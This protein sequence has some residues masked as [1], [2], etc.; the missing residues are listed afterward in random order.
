[1]IAIVTPIKDEINNLKR[2]FESLTLQTVVIDYLI[3]IENDSIDGTKEVLDKIKRVDNINNLIIK[4]ISFD[5]KSY[6]LGHK[7]ST[8]IFEGFSV[9]KKQEDY[10]DIDFI[11]ILDAD[12]FPEPQYYEKLI[13]FMNA[14]DKIGLA[15]GVLLL[16]DGSRGFSNR[17]HVR[18]S[19]RLWKKKCFDEAGYKIG[20]SADSNSRIKAQLR[21][22]S[23]KVCSEVVFYSR[24]ANS[25]YD[26]TYG[27]RSAYY[28]GF[29]P[30]YAYIKSGYYFIRRPKAGKSYLK[31][32]LTSKHKNLEKNP[33]IEIIN[34]NKNALKRKIVNFMKR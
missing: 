21:G 4:S 11:G 25:R 16:E 5:D 24:E 23:A 15:S 8:V 9:L 28:N 30:L 3:I 20:M 12:C 31:G 29:T 14:D 34:Y 17:N 22:W 33:D 6:Q 32:Y 27:G 19:G 10:E 18:G 26:L 1:M 7:Y 2:F 13:N